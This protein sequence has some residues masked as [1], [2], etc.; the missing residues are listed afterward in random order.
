MNHVKKAK[1]AKAASNRIWGIVLL[2]MLCAP[3]GSLHPASKE[4]GFRLFLPLAPLSWAFCG[5]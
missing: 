4:T 3:L 1:L 2:H 5:H